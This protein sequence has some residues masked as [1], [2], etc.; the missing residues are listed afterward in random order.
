MATLLLVHE[1]LLHY[2]VVRLSHMAQ[3]R[4]KALSQDQTDMH[5]TVDRKPVH[6]VTNF[7]PEATN[8]HTCVLSKSTFDV[9]LTSRHTHIHHTDILSGCTPALANFA[10]CCDN[11]QYK[12]NQHVR[13]QG[14][15]PQVI[16]PLRHRRTCH[17]T[18]SRIAIGIAAVGAP[19]LSSYFQS[20]ILTLLCLSCV[21]HPPGRSVNL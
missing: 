9:H 18:T 3:F 7:L 4:L 10:T 6:Q 1:S 14:T 17:L 12:P 21:K 16:I 20:L 19:K 13:N 2:Y 15:A 8:H 5:D 11:R